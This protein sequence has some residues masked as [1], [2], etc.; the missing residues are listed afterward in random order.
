MNTNHAALRIWDLPTRLFHT[1]LA[2]C[3]TA[4]IVTGE[5][6]GDSLMQ[7]HFYFGYAV[8]SL[9]FFRLIWGVVG[10]YWSRFIHFLPSPH[11]LRA[12]IAA[13]RHKENPQFISHNPLGALSVMAMLLLLLLQVFSGFMADDDISVS[14]PWA[15][16]VPSAWVEWASNYHTEIGKPLLLM[17]IALHIASVL[18]HRFVKQDDL[19]SPMKHGNKVLPA[20][21]RSSIDTTR[22]RL[23]AFAIWIVCAGVVYV[24][25]KLSPT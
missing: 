25:I 5:I 14:G 21:T 15:A 17:L 9:A 4:L 24:L 6:G 18:F 13:L 7:W 12:Y 1:L 8:L 16:R 19:I 23:L 10:G 22:T 2:L 11:T 20:T 3:F